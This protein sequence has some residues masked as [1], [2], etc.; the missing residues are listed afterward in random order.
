MD[1]FLQSPF[2][3]FPLGFNDNIHHEGNISKMPDFDI[4]THLERK[5]RTSRSL[6]KNHG[7]I[8]YFS[9]GSF[10]CFK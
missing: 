4:L 1:Y 3:H 5:K 8:I 10:Y 7:N 9:K 2:L 6:G